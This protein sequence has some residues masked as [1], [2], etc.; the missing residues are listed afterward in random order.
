M[1][2]SFVFF[3]YL[4]PNGT[5]VPINALTII[6]DSIILAAKAL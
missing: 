5:V 1:I 6:Q 2:F 3:L 4:L